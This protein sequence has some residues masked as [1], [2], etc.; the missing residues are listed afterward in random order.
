MILSS[1]DTIQIYDFYENSNSTN[2]NVLGITRKTFVKLNWH[3]IDNP[4]IIMFLL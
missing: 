1:D 2:Q 3:N 4:C